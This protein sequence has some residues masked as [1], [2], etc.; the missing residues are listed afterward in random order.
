VSLSDD[1]SPLAGAVCVLAE[2]RLD[3]EAGWQLSTWGC[4]WCAL[5]CQESTEL[6]PYVS[7]PSA[8][9]IFLLLAFGPSFTTKGRLMFPESL[10]NEPDLERGE[11]TEDSASDAWE[12]DVKGLI[13]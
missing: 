11:D 10:S 1:D 4:E 2:L 5:D 13:D 12:G 9:V 7:S 3:W 6:T 8:T